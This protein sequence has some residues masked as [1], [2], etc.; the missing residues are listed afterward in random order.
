MRLDVDFENEEPEL[1]KK[2]KCY[3]GIEQNVNI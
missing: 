1:S 2:K 3:N